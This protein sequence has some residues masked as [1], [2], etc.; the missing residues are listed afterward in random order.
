MNRQHRGTGVRSTLASCALGACLLLI[1]AGP[2]A[3]TGAGAGSGN[4]GG[5]ADPPA[6][7]DGS[8]ARPSVNSTS[9]DPSNAAPAGPQRPEISAPAP[10]SAVLGRTD[11]YILR[12]T[13]ETVA[14]REAATHAQRGMAVQSVLTEVF[15]GEIADLTPAQVK[16]L[17]LNPRVSVIQPDTPVTTEATQSP[18]TWGL[19]RIDQRNRPLSNSYS[20][21]RTGSGVKV[22]VVDSGI[23]A[24]SDFGSRIARGTNAYSRFN[25][26]R[27][28]SDCDGHGTHVAGIIGGTTYGVAKGVTLVPVRVLD[29]DGGA[30]ASDVIAALDWIIRDHAAGTPAVANLSLGLGPNDPLDEAVRAT[31]AD[32]ISVVVAAGNNSGQDSCDRSPSRVAAA[33]TVGAIDSSDRR[34]SFSNRGPCVD[35]FA[36]GESITSTGLDGGT[37]VMSGTSMATPHVAGTAALLLDETPAAGPAAIATTLLSRSVVGVLTNV[38]DGSPNRL[39]NTGATLPASRPAAP[40]GVSATAPTTSSTTVTWTRS[41]S[42]SILDQTINAYSDGSLV[43]SVVVPA[44][45]RST[46]FSPLTLGASYTFTVQA[47][48][49]VG[50]SAESTPSSAVVHRTAPGTP[51]SLSASVITSGETTGRGRVSWVVSSVGGSPLLDQTVRTYRAGILVATTTVAGTDTSFTTPSPLDVGVA[52]RFTVQAR[53]AV[54]SSSFS[55]FSNT[56]TR[57]VAPS[58]PV[59]ISA[60]LR[61]TTTARV[62]WTT[63]SNGGSAL[64]EQAVNIHVNGVFLRSVTVSGSTR[65][66]TTEELAVGKA[67]TFTV[68]ARN[69]AGWGAPSAASSSVI[70]LR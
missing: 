9:S 20:Y 51:G 61:T 5:Q 37:A 53:N 46:T 69:A 64:T 39:L 54:G 22:Y 18:V 65:A 47:R 26:S 60:A 2:S 48:N 12:F 23:A 13:P 44:T 33:I 52:Y 7:S 32:G 19:D 57:I 4:W 24:H 6:S 50:L 17:R 30:E 10:A 43:R 45:A 42:P 35:L 3:A 21:D 63:G 67:Y 31:I 1:T 59:S 70:R 25:D 16:G 58:E 11:R 41:T 15:P 28:T 27:G 8:S 55:S 40:T 38:G 66:Y 36:P 29:C 14:T 62:T 49:A 68:Q 56:I 34:A